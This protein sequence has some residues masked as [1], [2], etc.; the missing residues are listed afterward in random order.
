MARRAAQLDATRKLSETINGL[1]ITSSSKVRDFV[2]EH[3]EIRSATEAI[4]R[5]AVITQE[6]DLPDGTSEVT[7]TVPLRGVYEAIKPYIRP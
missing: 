7:V 2:I 4:V 3:D 6:Q 5:G 1:S